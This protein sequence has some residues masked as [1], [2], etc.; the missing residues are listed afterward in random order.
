[1][2]ARVDDQGVAFPLA[3]GITQEGWRKVVPQLASIEEDLAPR[4]V[5]FIK[6]RNDVRFL[7]H[8]PRWGR[9]IDP[10]DAS[11]QA[12][13]RGILSRMRAV[14]ALVDKRLGPRHKWHVAGFEISRNVQDVLGAAGFPN[15][16]QVRM[17]IGRSWRR[18]GEVGLAI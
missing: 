9:G 13:C 11:G 10:R 15:S 3:R 17:A 1:E 7:D 18:R 16:R 8:L 14:C 2:T 6:N 12:V 4:V 5:G